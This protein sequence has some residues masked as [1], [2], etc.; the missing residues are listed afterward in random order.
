MDLAV[1]NITDLQSEIIRLEKLKQQQ[2]MD[3]KERFNSPSSIFS[4]F[5][6]LFPEHNGPKTG[7][8][9]NQDI[10]GLLSR[11]VLPFALN[12]TL[13]KGQGVLVKTLVGLVSQKAS[14]YISEDSVTG[15]WDKAKDLVTGIFKKATHKAEQEHPVKSAV[16]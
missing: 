2:E 8:I 10:W 15:V 4:A 13:F 1:K 12:K 6:S 7:S 14:S 16:L 5:K 9:F 3:L 11:V